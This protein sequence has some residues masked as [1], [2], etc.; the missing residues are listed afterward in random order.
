MNFDGPRQISF[1][2]LHNNYSFDGHFFFFTSP[3]DGHFSR[4]L[5]L[6]LSGHDGFLISMIT[7]SD[8]KKRK[9]STNFLIGKNE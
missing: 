2:L 7:V 4:T 9:H 1:F 6:S 3:F 5:E 8:N